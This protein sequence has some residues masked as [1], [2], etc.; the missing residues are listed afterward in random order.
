MNKELRLRLHLLQLK[1][2]VEMQ[3]IREA[4]AVGKNANEACSEVIGGTFNLSPLV[5]EGVAAHVLD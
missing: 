4:L 2:A 1:D 3:A 5:K